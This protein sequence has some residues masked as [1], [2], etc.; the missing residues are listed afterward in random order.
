VRIF[1]NGLKADDNGLKADDA[2]RAI[3]LKNKTFDFFNAGDDPV[4]VTKLV[5]TR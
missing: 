4:V 5:P 3:Y 1:S 2:P